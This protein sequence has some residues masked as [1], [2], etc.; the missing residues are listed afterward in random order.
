M[1]ERW[2]KTEAAYAHSNLATLRG[3]RYKSLNSPRL[4]VERALST[5]PT[6]PPRVWGRGVAA[7]LT[8]GSAPPRLITAAVR[9][10]IRCITPSSRDDDISVLCFSGVSAGFTRAFQTASYR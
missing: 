2:H 8:G 4:C 1:L 5:T 3:G 6:Q 10:Q 9:L 7:L